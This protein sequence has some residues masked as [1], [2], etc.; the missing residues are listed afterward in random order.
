MFP[1]HI[2]LRKYLRLLFIDLIDCIQKGLV[3]HS[4]DLAEIEYIQE[5]RDELLG[6]AVVHALKVRG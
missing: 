4:L 5:V 3:R 2:L 6:V 1:L